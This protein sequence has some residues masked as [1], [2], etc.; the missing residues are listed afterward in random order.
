MHLHH[1]IPRSRGGTDSYVEWKSEYDHAYDHALDFVL[2]DNAPVFDCRH[3]AWPLLPADLQEAVR[4]KLRVIWN[5]RQSWKGKRGGAA[6]REK[7][8]GICAENFGE[9]VS[10]NMRRLVQSQEHWFQ[11]PEHSE[12]VTNFNLERFSNGTHPLQQPGEC[13]I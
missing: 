11:T 5:S 13:P 9:A 2:F 6:A 8:V 1:I 7:R 10:V 12:R 3:T 4:D